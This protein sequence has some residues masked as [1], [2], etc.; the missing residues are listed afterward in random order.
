MLSIALFKKILNTKKIYIFM[1]NKIEK[2][3]DTNIKLIIYTNLILIYF[4]AMN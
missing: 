3:I 2:N 1:F 4:G